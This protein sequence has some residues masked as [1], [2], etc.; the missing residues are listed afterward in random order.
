MA[1][2]PVVITAVIVILDQVIKYF[3]S[4][5]LMTGEIT[6]IK[7][8][9]YLTY[10]ENYGI[11]FGMFQNKTLFFLITQSV[12]SI[13][14]V[15]LIYRLYKVHFWV[16]VCLAMILGGALGNLID[17][18]R[19]GYVV[20]YLRFTFFPPVFNLADSAIVA[21]AILLGAIVILDK[22]INI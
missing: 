17:R 19:L 5:N 16:T 4:A 18:A 9:F 15:L 13:V 1:L 7:N 20:D 10:V 22:N 12:I 11:A 14:I 2:Y 3:V 6:V 21:G 8:F